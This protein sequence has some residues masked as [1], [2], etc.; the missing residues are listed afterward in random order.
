MLQEWNGPVASQKKKKPQRSPYAAAGARAAPSPGRK[1]GGHIISRT[2][3]QPPA[4]PPPPP[5]PPLP[6]LSSPPLSGCVHPSSCANRH[7][8][9][10][11]LELVK[12]TPERGRFLSSHAEGGGTGHSSQPTFF[13]GRQHTRVTCHW[14]HSTCG[15]PGG[16]LQRPGSSAQR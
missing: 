2:P 8:Y 15:R 11:C 14:H 12:T 13:P 6:P 3:P 7:F 1:A 9:H 10:R 4:L 16:G 5:P